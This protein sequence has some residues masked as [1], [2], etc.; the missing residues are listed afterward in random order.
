VHA[1]AAAWFVALALIISYPLVSSLDT[2]L[3]GGGAGDNLAFLWNSWWAR[4]VASRGTWFGYFHTTY[5]FAPFGAPLVLNTHTALESF[6]AA[7]GLGG[8]AIV[9]A[10]NLILLAG[11]AANGL[12]AYSLAFSF[13]RRALP[14]IVAGTSFATCAYLS[15]HLLGHVNLTHA[16][17]LPLAAVAWASF[18]AAPSVYRASG[19]ALAFAA[20]IWSDYYYFVYASLF[21]GIW[22]VLTARD[23]QV[24]WP[25][26]RHRLIER[27]L[28][29]VAGVAAALAATIWLTGGITLDL[30]GA[31]VTAQQ[32]RN[33]TSIAGICLLAWAAARARVTARRSSDVPSW[34]PIVAHGSLALVLFVILAG[35]VI[36]AGLGLLRSGGYVSQPYFWRSGPRGVDMA[37]VILGPPMHSLVGSLTSAL[38]L[39]LGIDR[40]EQTGWLGVVASVLLI[41]AARSRAA[42]GRDALRWLWVCAIFG[43]WSLGPSLSIAGADTG[44]FL[45]QAFVRCIPVVSNARMPGRALVMVQL[46]SAVLGAMVLSRWAWKPIALILLVAAIVLEGF[47]APFPLFRLPVA[48]AVDTRLAVG[49]GPIVELPSGLRDGFGEWGRFDSRALVHQM[50][51]GRPLV[52]GF[53]ARLSPGTTAAYRAEPALAALFELSSGRL[54]ADALQPDLGSALA[55]SGISDVVVNTDAL[56]SPVRDAFSKRGLHLIVQDGT[57][58]LYEV[59]RRPPK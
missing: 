42:L 59:T 8:V 57:R 53:S 34:T 56:T 37:T 3:P 21:A 23:V 24:T 14:S 20:V 47:T 50:A 7:V 40:I 45:P 30:A 1:A 29:A 35:P 55:R 54:A 41:V 58:E 6:A 44:L 17:V 51:H 52:G 49:S 38:D 11:L 16:W 4:H 13:V 15:V 33:P 36:V 12:A 26:T 9:R 31:H 39:R 25:V 28:M 10:H 18:V 46:A 32:P 2:H 48:D 5:L 27:G 22:L 43:I 19:V